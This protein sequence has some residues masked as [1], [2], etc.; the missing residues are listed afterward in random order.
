MAKRDRNPSISSEELEKITP[1]SLLEP[2]SARANQTWQAAALRWLLEYRGFDAGS[3]DAKSGPYEAKDLPLS[4]AGA[5]Y[6]RQ[7]TEAWSRMSDDLQDAAQLRELNSLRARLAAAGD[8]RA[9]AFSKKLVREQTEESEIIEAGIIKKRDRSQ[10][11][12][13][14]YLHEGF[15]MPALLIAA[16]L[17]RLTGGGRA[18][19]PANA[20]AD[21]IRHAVVQASRQIDGEIEKASQS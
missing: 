3:P 13:I 20:N 11:V 15:E 6:C 17:G 2:G 18:V 1:P 16:M 21:A 5:E 4:D 10:S 14:W 8:E 19:D 12:L 7:L 9:R